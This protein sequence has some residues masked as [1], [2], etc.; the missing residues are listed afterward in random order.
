MPLL[1]LA[2]AMMAAASRK[3]SNVGMGSWLANFSMSYHELMIPFAAHHLSAPGGSCTLP[4]ISS[5]PPSSGWRESERRHITNIFL[6]DKHSSWYH[7]TDLTV[8]VS[9]TC[10]PLVLPSDGN[11]QRNVFSMPAQD[12]TLATFE[13]FK[14]AIRNCPSIV[15]VSRGVVT[16]AGTGRIEWASSSKHTYSLAVALRSEGCAM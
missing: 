14:K 4:R 13:S 8:C 11:K 6:E 7:R 1:F 5:S 2:P 12:N 3:T 9:Y 15:G 16:R 10:S